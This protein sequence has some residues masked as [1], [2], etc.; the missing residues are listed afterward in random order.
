MTGLHT[1]VRE[2]EAEVEQMNKRVR[3]NLVPWPSNHL[4]IFQPRYIRWHRTVHFSERQI[5]PLDTLG[6]FFQNSGPKD[7][8]F[9][10]E[11][12]MQLS[13][14]QETDVSCM[15][16]FFCVSQFLTVS[17]IFKLLS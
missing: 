6:T 2:T 3:K 11:K 17:E 15:D 10:T 1:V 13:L 7:L 5:L 12:A 8:L 4:I 14:S 9:V 16:S